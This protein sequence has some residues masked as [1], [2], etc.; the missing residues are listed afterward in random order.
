MNIRLQIFLAR[1]G[2]A[3]SRRKAEELIKAGSVKI[4]GKVA[5][6]GD[7]ADTA[8]DKVE[9]SG[10]KLEPIKKKIYL[11]LNK[12][13][14]YLVAKSDAR[15]RPLAYDLLKQPSTDNNKL[16]DAEF[17]SLFNVGRLDL[18]TEGLLLF[19]NEGDFALKLTHPRYHI[20]K[21]YIA[22]IEGRISDEAVWKLTKGVWVTVR[23]PGL[24][25]RYR[26]KPATVRILGRGVDYSIIVIRI[27]EGRK[28][29]IR[30]MCEA[31]GHP[32]L[33]LKRT[34][35]GELELKDLPIGK[36]KFLTE[37]EVSDLR[38]LLYIKEQKQKERAK[39]RGKFRQ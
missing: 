4:N 11:M 20:K 10:Q 2:L 6:L 17:N 22:K 9:V 14:G 13:V 12:P 33:T 19:T 27:S 23:E 3:S 8:K 15:K 28:R 21:V 35:I 37:K 31:V 39:F 36:W 7:R 38:R 26:T 24:T 18:N 34:Q 16:T 5:K 30:R 1:A 25:E 32:V 29:E